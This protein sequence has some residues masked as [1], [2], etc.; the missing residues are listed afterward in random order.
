MNA[1]KTTRRSTRPKSMRKTR[2]VLDR[3]GHSA[4]MMTAKDMGKRTGTLLREVERHGAV[5]ISRS[6]KPVAVALAP[7]HFVALCVA[8]ATAAIARSR[9]VTRSS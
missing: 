9:V 2:R 7:D 5:A 6:G 4:L 1:T 8:Y 3:K